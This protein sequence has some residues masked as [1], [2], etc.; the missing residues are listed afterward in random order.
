MRIPYTHKEYREVIVLFTS[1]VNNN[2]GVKDQFAVFFVMLNITC[3]TKFCTSF[4]K[5][6]MCSDFILSISLLL[7]S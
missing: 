7:L 3:E 2:N 1:Q 5:H 6:F 4:F